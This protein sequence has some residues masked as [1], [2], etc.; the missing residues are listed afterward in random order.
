MTTYVEIVP[1][2]ESL[3]PPLC[4]E[5][6]WWQ[7]PVWSREAPNGD[8]ARQLWLERLSRDWGSCGTAAVNGRDT[9][10]AVQFAPLRS[11]PRAQN[12]LAGLSVAESSDA[13]MLFC[14]RL[15]EGRPEYEAGSLLHRALSSLHER[16]TPEVHAL[17]R[18]LG[19][20]RSYA[21]GNVFGLEFLLA[22]GFRHVGRSG[23]LDVVRCDL[24]GLLPVFS[25]LLRA[26]RSI[27]HTPPAPTPV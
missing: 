14:L 12:L 22:N 18:P 11:L 9:L 24:R 13:V 16:G 1:A 23:R 25:D 3:L 19:S 8:G 15:R 26:W 6:L 20:R 27:R 4:R 17:A 21:R 10:G 2:S 5:C 7:R